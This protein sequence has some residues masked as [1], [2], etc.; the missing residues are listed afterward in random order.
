MNN[1]KKIIVAFGD[2]L[3]A[4]YGVPIENSYP[5]LLQKKLLDNGFNYKVINLGISG[6]TTYNGL[7]RFNFVIKLKPKL[8]ILTLG[9]NDALQ[10][11]SPKEAKNNL[12]KMIE[13]LIKDKIKI[14]LGGMYSP[15]EHGPEY[16]N[17]FDSIYPNLAELFKLPLIPFF[18]EGIALDSKYC[19]EDNLHPNSEGYKKIVEENIWKY[20]QDLLVK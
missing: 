17:S 18:L 11:L 12:S 6:D 13:Q 10:K 8:V 7:Q 1:S 20:L 3:T 2:S 14:L 9:A 16:Y 19:L 15:R 5:F 4:G